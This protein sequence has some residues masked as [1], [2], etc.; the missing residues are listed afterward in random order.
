MT[1]EITEGPDENYRSVVTR[2]ERYILRKKKKKNL[3]YIFSL[4]LSIHLFFSLSI[5]AP[6][7]EHTNTLSVCLS[8]FLYSLSLYP[9]VSLPIPVNHS[10]L[11]VTSDRCYQ[12]HLPSG[13][14]RTTPARYED[15][16]NNFYRCSEGWGCVRSLEI[17][18]AK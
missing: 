15:G 2:R 14:P 4:C 10:Y 6:S 17:A 11:S 18:E 3:I 8:L 12:L 13:V 1:R 9:S 5:P 7:L 16:H